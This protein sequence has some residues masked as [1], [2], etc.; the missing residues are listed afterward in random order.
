MRKALAK[1]F[2]ASVGIIPVLL[3]CGG[4]GGGYGGSPANSIMSGANGSSAS[5]N[6]AVSSGAGQ[7]DYGTPGSPQFA[8]VGG[9]TFAGSSNQS[10]VA[11]SAV[12]RN[13]Q[14]GSA[15]HSADDTTVTVIGN[16][17][18]TSVVRVAIPSLGIDE[19][20]NANT[21]LRGF[22]GDTA[23]YGLTYVVLGEWAHWSGTRTTSYTESVFGYETPISAVPTS[24]T[25]QFSGWA[26]GA[27]FKGSNSGAWVDGFANVSVDFVSGKVSGALTKMRDGS[28]QPWNDVSVSG[29]IIGGTNK[30]SGTTAATSA[31]N[32]S[33]SLTGGATG[34]IDGGFYGPAAE[35]VGAVWTLTDSSG[36]A[37]GGLVGWR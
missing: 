13:L 29:S 32:S 24:G 8:T 18:N 1:A 31:P 10:N 16:A 12:S 28:A 9:P 27:V 34:R 36:S 3:A 2:A 23:Y 25:A 19:T 35:Q 15:I 7:W 11:F 14:S 4:G 5:P 22:Q 30:F 20:F 21:D 6:V 17:P 26:S 33:L 37:V